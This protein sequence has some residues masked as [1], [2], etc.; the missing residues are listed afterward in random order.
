MINTT[1][2]F[3]KARPDT[4]PPFEVFG[5]NH[6]IA[7]IIT[8]S[9]AVGLPILLKN[10][11]FS[12]LREPYRYF[13]F[14]AHLTF[15]ITY[16]LW[17]IFFMPE[18][19]VTHLGLHLCGI[20]IFI[21]LVTLLTKNVKLY[22][23]V[24]FWGL[25]AAPQAILTPDIGVWGFPHYHFFHVFISHGL[26]VSSILFLTLV[27][28]LRPRKGAL[29]RIF[30][31]TNA[32]MLIVA[33]I[34]YLLGTNYLFICHKPPNSLMDFL[35]PWPWYILS[36]E[37]IGLALFALLYLPVIIERHRKEKLEKGHS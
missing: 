34:N 33:P 7:I 32:Y 28:G 30:I 29:L 13:L 36:L 23:I 2:E 12:F 6:V 20:A 22:E 25:G 14:G 16:R 18:K 10:R 27:D 24:Y 15:E 31:Y 1:L 5:F 35:G 26:L 4:I 37:A 11:R 8:F 3:L 21:N 17:Y 19:I 9:L